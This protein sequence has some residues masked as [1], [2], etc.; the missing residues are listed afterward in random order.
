MPRKIEREGEEKDLIFGDTHF[1]FHDSRYISLLYRVLEQERFKHIIAIGDI[2]DCYAI[3][4]F[5]KDPSKV[6][7]YNFS[8]EKDLVIPFL[9]KIKDLQSDARCMFIPGNHE[10][11]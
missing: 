11:R 9:A 8:L 2:F 10:Y 4:K 3:S 1:P 7:I 5:L 6:N